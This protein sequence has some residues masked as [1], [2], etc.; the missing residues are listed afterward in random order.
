MYGWCPH[1]EHLIQ[2]LC[3]KTEINITLIA[4]PRPHDV[5]KNLN[6]TG[7][8]SR[9][10]KPPLAIAAPLHT[11]GIARRAKNALDPAPNAQNTAQPSIYTPER[12]KPTVRRI[13]LRNKVT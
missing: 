11:P 4:A 13:R 3:A 8:L 1:A 2:A 6:H 7:Y 12:S 5:I 10:Y 9:A